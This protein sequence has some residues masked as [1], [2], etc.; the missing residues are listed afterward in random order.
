MK[1]KFATRC[2]HTGEGHNPFGAHATPIYQTSTYVF[3]SAEQA[4][5]SRQLALYLGI[6]SI[7]SHLDKPG[8]GLGLAYDHRVS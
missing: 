2:V 8:R 4:A 3:E 1:N 5:A 6:E 7:S